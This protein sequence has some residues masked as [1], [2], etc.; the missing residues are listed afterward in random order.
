MFTAEERDRVRQQVLTR[1]EADSAITGA[2]F[3]GSHATSDDDRWSDIDLVLA[4]QGELSPVLDRWTGW[5]YA[6][7]GARHHWDLPAGPS[8]IRVFL[9]PDDLTAPLAGTLVRAPDE[10]ELRRALAATI[11]VVTAELERS[12]PGLTE[13]LRPMLAE[14]SGSG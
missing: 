14:L 2:A 4:V 6:E 8:I 3:T 11:D 5:L 12:D 10:P 13:R 9:L 7:L 1:A